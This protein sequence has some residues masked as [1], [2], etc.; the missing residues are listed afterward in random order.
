ML[1]GCRCNRFDSAGS[2]SYEPLTSM[3]GGQN[4]RHRMSSECACMLRSISTRCDGTPP[5]VFCC[6]LADTWLGLGL[7][8]GLGWGLGLGLGLG[9]GSS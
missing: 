8:W 9:E 6:M 2:P 7:G 3:Q 4:A 5:L 1:R